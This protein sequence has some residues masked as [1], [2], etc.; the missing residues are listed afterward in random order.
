MAHPAPAQRTA[1]NHLRALPVQRELID[2]ACAAVHKKLTDFV[3]D[4]ACR[5]AEHVLCD[6][7]QFLLDEQAYAAFEVALD[8]PLPD[9]HAVQRLLAHKAPWED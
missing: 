5:E 4:A 8:Q 7:R 1:A 6:R 2:R 9:N 3:L